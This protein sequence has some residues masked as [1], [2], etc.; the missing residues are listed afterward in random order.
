MFPPKVVSRYQGHVVNFKNSSTILILLKLINLKIINSIYNSSIYVS[1]E[2][3][4][5]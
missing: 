3:C 4:R 5:L 1:S 2:S